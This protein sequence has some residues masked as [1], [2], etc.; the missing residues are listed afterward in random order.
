MLLYPLSILMRNGHP[1]CCYPRSQVGTGLSANTIL[2][3]W[4]LR[5]YKH[6]VSHFIDIVN[7]FNIINIRPISLSVPPIPKVHIKWRAQANPINHK[8]PLNLR[9]KLSSFLVLTSP[10]LLLPATNHL[11]LRIL[12]DWLRRPTI[13]ESLLTFFVILEIQT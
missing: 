9:R 12:Y 11:L 4:L 13:C 3:T 7:I 8:L 2:N 6:D 5:Y 10:F 1:N